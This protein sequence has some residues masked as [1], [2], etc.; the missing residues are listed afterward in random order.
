MK[1]NLVHK[2]K[3]INSSLKES[4][5]LGMAKDQSLK[6]EIVH[7]LTQRLTSMTSTPNQKET[8]QQTKRVCLTTKLFTLPQVKMCTFKSKI[9][10]IL[11]PT[12]Y[13]IIDQTLLISI[14]SFITQY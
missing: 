14:Y 3:K 11:E 1:I 4:S 10:W 5:A 9:Q 2:Q 7:K 13:L 12:L 6:P 8:L